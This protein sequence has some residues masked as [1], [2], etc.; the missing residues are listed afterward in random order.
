VPVEEGRY[1]ITPQL[2]RQKIDENT[3]GAHAWHALAAAAPAAGGSGGRRQLCNIP[4]QSNSLF[5]PMHPLG[6]VKSSSTAAGRHSMGTCHTAMA[7]RLLNLKLIKQLVP[8]S[9]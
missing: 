1:G 6:C 9:V 4:C 7:G 2:A 3:I 8:Y 5:V